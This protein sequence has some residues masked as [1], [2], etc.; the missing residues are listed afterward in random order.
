MPKIEFDKPEF[1]LAVL[2]GAQLALWTLIPALTYDAPPLDV[3][4]G[5]LWGRERVLA[6]Y[7]HPALPSWTLEIGRV[8]TGATGWPAYLTSQL[9]VVASLSA[10][11][12]LGRDLLG[13]WR[14]LAGTCL[15]TGVT[16]YSWTT[17]NFNHDVAM[18]PIWAGFTLA[19]WRAV[20]R[21]TIAGWVMAATLAA[22]A[23]HTKLASLVLLS[24]AALWLLWDGKARGRLPSAPPWVGLAAW[25]ALAAPLSVW[26]LDNGHQMLEYGTSRAFGRSALG[27]VPFV[28]GVAAAVAG[29]AL[30]GA[31]AVLPL[32]RTIRAPVLGLSLP[33]DIDARARRYLASV[34][35]GPLLLMII[36]AQVTGGGMKTSWAVPMLGG[37][38][39][40]AMTFI[41]ERHVEDVARR[42][43]RLSLL[44]LLV[45]A[46]AHA[47]YVRTASLFGRPDRVN[48]PSAEISSRLSSAWR[49]ATGRPL[50]IVAGEPWVAGLVGIGV[51]PMPSVLTFGDLALSPW[52]TPERLARDGALIL[53]GDYQQRTIAAAGQP[54]K[55]P[56]KIRLIVGE[57]PIRSA[58]F[59]WPLN[60]KLTEIVI[61]YA[62][63]PP[64]SP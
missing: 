37:A 43:S 42:I 31:L 10:T 52:I 55:P 21:N 28:L 4:E 44:V 58:T 26:L 51:D 53:W 46:L 20:E 17:P 49:E 40:L 19:L 32:A 35:L 15:L 30:I 14:A 22:A 59:Q 8:L 18:M 11:F 56:D 27:A 36:I 39:L 25:L 61:G 16:F 57:L 3:V 34:T 29:G 50:S 54:P 23:L 9:F 63:L 12:L 47:A 48:W 2:C 62:I 60:P 38:G 24:S 45:V 33:S 7:K 5:Y 1:A 6:T 13:A 64:R 41:D